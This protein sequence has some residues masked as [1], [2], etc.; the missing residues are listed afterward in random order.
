MALGRTHSSLLWLYLCD[1]LTSC[2][3]AQIENEFDAKLAD[4]AD[5]YDSFLDYNVVLATDELSHF[6]S[7]FTSGGV[8]FHEGTWSTSSGTQYT[9]LIVQVPGTQM[10]L[11]LVQAT[12]LAVGPGQKPPHRLEQRVSETVLQ[13]IQ[14]GSA[15]QALAVGRAASDYAMGKLE[16]FYVG[17]G[18]TVSHAVSEAD[19]TKKCFLWTGATTEVCYT[20]RAPSST[21]G[22]FKVCN[23]EDALNSV[24][25]NLI[26][27]K[28]MC[29]DDKWE[30][31]HY[32]IDSFRV[33]KVP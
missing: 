3:A 14:A 19:V 1:T 9:S 26:K 21:K 25:T 29:G 6:K 11:E 8:K 20:N 23:F 27:G 28:P 7:T 5:R 4:I 15:L 33:S 22:D 2:L 13:K 18:A 17:M 12:S 10:V 16:G 24:H 31:N 32:A 30:D